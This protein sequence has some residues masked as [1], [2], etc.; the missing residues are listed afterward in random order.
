MQL[1]SPLFITQGLAFPE[2]DRTRQWPHM[3]PDLESLHVLSTHCA[4]RMESDTRESTYSLCS[5]LC[6]Q[7]SVT[8]QGTRRP[9]ICALVIYPLGQTYLPIFSHLALKRNETV[10]FRPHK[11]IDPYWVYRLESVK[12]HFWTPRRNVVYPRCYF[13]GKVCHGSEWG[14]VKAQQELEKYK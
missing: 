3:L 13:N 10:E 9:G 11:L 12:K 14:A 6:V 2:I 1:S 5:S 7:S 4:S 8:G